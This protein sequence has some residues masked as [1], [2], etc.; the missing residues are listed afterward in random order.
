[1]TI[2]ESV[3]DYLEA[4]LRLKQENGMVRSID[5]VHLLNYTKP[6]IS[7][8]MSRLRENGYIT[9]DKEGW[10]EL[11]DAGRA[12]AEPVYERHRLLS[13]WLIALGVDPQVAREDACKIEHDIS[14]QTFECI[15][16]H[17]AKNQP[18]KK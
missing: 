17:I 10:L 8:A 16:A 2:N 6:S 5:V 1:M 18:A 14:S 7:R 11:T 15:R 13:Q 9:M 3:E 12:I 4:I